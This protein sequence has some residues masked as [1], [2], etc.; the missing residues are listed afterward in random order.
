M[1]R[2]W[3]DLDSATRNH[4]QQAF[5]TGSLVQEWAEQVPEISL[6]Q[7]FAYASDPNPGEQPAI[8]RALRRDPT[9]QTRYQQVLDAL[10]ANTLVV[11]SAAAS[12]PDAPAAGLTAN[13]S[14]QRW[15]CRLQ[16]SSHPPHDYYL[17]IEVGANSEAPTRLCASSNTEGAIDLVLDTAHRG[18]IQMLLEKDH[19]LISIM[20]DPDR[21]IRM[22]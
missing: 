18:V 7:L 4:I 11:A 16:V 9:T 3:K 17:I 2:Q 5:I 13:D 12:V 8:A 21:I 14:P 10:C 6:R 20:A 22:W 1:N 19:P 15:R